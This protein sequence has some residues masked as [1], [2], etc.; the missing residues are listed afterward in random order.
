LEREYQRLVRVLGTLAKGAPAQALALEK[1]RSLLAAMGSTSQE[2]EE[3][4]QDGSTS[5]REGTN[6]A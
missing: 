3:V 4:L 5:W 1:L 6:K 2:L